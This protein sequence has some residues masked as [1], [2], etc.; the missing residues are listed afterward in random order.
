ML[1]VGH[2]LKCAAPVAAIEAAISRARYFAKEA[3]RALAFVDMERVLIECGTLQASDAITKPVHR[4]L[5]ASGSRT[6]REA[7]AGSRFEPTK[8]D[9]SPVFAP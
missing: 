4:A 1:L 8:P 2:A 9:V 5:S 3:G 6:L 7:F